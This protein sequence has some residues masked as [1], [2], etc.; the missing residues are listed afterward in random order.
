ML[1]R[2]FLRLP[3]KNKKILL[4]LAPKGQ[5]VNK[6]S[7]KYFDDKNDGTISRSKG[8]SHNNQHV[9]DL[10]IFD[11]KYDISSNFMNN[12]QRESSS[13]I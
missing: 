3:R 10:E 4:C 12:L 13:K 8:D 7:D 9:Q 6:D 1:G 11:N 2:Y 5:N